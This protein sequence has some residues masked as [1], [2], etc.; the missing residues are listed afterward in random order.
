MT[1]KHCDQ[2]KRSSDEM[3]KSEIDYA[4]FLS[5]NIQ[6][7]LR[8]LETRSDVVPDSR[9]P[10]FS[11][12]LSKGKAFHLPNSL[13]PKQLRRKHISCNTEVAVGK[14][15]G[16]LLEKE[17]GQ[18]AYGRVI[19]MN[20]P[21][22]HQGDTMAIKVQSPTD[23]LAWEY[24]LLQRLEERLISDGKA[25]LHYAFPRP[26]SFISFADG[27]ILSMSAASRSGLNLVDLSN[28]YKLKL[29]KPVPE[30]IA[31]HYTSIALKI[32]EKLHWYGKI[33]VRSLPFNW[34]SVGKHHHTLI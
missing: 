31:L 5:H 29:G 15:G 4:H 34:E 26:M 19:L 1:L 6:M 11:L 2:L 3:Q 27:G 20:V 25:D 12:L 30:L 7:A 28:F 33:L 22:N 21:S 9:S 16:L 24:L 14:H 10:L 18:G 13:L 17:L 32:I 8:R 23:S